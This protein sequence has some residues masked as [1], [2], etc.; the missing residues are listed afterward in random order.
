MPTSPPSMIRYIFRFFLEKRSNLQSCISL[1]I[2]Y[3]GPMLIVEA[4]A[5]YIIIYFFQRQW[6]V[7]ILASKFADP[8][9]K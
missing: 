6:A 8:P 7:R 5:T 1:P 9:K 2:V 3:N 4:V